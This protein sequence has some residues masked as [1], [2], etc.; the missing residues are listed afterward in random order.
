MNNLPS[1]CGLVD[2]RISA[3]DKDLPVPAIESVVVVSLIFVIFLSKDFARCIEATIILFLVLETVGLWSFKQVMQNLLHGT[4]SFSG[5]IPFVDC[6]LPACIDHYHVDVGDH[7]GGCVDH[8]RV[9][10]S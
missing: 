3:S 4:I 1:Y 9:D 2:A 7:P 6:A 8:Y 5:L 10:T